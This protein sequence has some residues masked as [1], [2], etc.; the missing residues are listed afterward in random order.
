MHSFSHI[1]NTV[2]ALGYRK[3]LVSAQYLVNKSIEFD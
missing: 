2:I 3:D 1:Y